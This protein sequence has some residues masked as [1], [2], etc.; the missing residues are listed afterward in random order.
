MR[1]ANEKIAAKQVNSPAKTPVAAQ[2]PTPQPQMTVITPKRLKKPGKKPE[3]F[4]AEIPGSEK[5]KV[6]KKTRKTAVTT[7][8]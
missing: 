1:L 5:K 8:F 4:I 6:S 7:T 3:A 2:L